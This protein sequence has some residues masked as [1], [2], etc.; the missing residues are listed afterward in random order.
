MSEDRLI[1]LAIHTYEKAVMLKTL[2]E[3][4]GVPVVLHNVNLTQPV[5]SSGVRVR[6]KEKDLPLSLRIVENA[7][8]FTNNENLPNSRQKIIVPIDFSDYSFKAAKI[9]FHLA[10]INNASII[11]LHSFID[12]FFNENIQLSNNP[13][14]ELEL[15]DARKLMEE[16]INSEMSKFT[17]QIKREIKL[18]EIPPIKFTTDIREGVPEDVITEYAKLSMPMLIVMGTRGAGKKEKELIGSVTAEVLDSCRV[19]VFSVP[20][21]A[22]IKSINDIK[23]VLFFSNLDQDDIIALDSLHRLFPDCHLHIT[24]I[25][26]IDKKRNIISNN[27][28][29]ALLSY[30]QRNFSNHSFSTE[31]FKPHNILTEFK[32]IE[33]EK[34]YNLII[35]PNKKKNI[36]ARLFNPSLAHRILF[37]ADIPMMVI[38]V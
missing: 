33:K 24:L 10:K 34:N 29:N 4:E 8:I 30:C 7:D 15:G 3:N 1:T 16:E 12:P 37:N 11:F 19:P 38:P 23:H 21:L 31:I 18:G 14:Y 35:V 36:F 9:A 26:I 22:P 28:I 13:T 32:N 6:I 20:E 25:Q 5:V 27:A 17:S 2:L